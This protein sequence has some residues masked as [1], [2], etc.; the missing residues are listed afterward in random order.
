[1]RA[2]WIGA[3]TAAATLAAAVLAVACGEGRAIFDVDVFSF[4][5]AG[6]DTIH[7]NVAFP[8][9]D[10]VQNTPIKMSLPGGP[11]KSVVDSV[12]LSGAANILNNTGSGTVTFRIF[13]DTSSAATYTDTAFVSTSGSAGPGSTTT[14][15]TAAAT[16]VGDQRFLH[17]TLW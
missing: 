15:I 3:G 17:Q 2:K 7:Y 16:V 8:I 12:T 14:P 5:N 10:S 4:L 9:T 6:A 11:A 13:I 1:M